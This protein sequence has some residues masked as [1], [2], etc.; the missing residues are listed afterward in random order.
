[1]ENIPL[2][3]HDEH[4]LSN[5]EPVQSGVDDE[6][7]GESPTTT[8]K[9]FERSASCGKTVDRASRFLF[10]FVFVVFNVFYWWHFL[11]ESRPGSEIYA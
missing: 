1:M 2:K 7:T 6:M 4:N 9:G 11:I 10:P 8:Q 3:Q 5:G